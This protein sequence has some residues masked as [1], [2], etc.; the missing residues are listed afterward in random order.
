MQGFVLRP[1]FIFAR[2]NNLAHFAMGKNLSVKMDAVAAVA[3][4]SVV[5]GGDQQI[6]ECAEIVSGA[7]KLA[8]A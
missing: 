3:L 2:E 4:D 8:K 5:N 1:G 7:Q 6:I